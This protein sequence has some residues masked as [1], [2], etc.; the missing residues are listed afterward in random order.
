[1]FLKFLQL[2]TLDLCRALLMKT[3]YIFQR[4]TR[5]VT[6]NS[7]LKET[8]GSSSKKSHTGAKVAIAVIG[9]I[10]GCAVLALLAFFVIR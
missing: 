5:L 10:V 6:P 7:Q 9:A 1:M 4:P 8:G 2:L 3:L